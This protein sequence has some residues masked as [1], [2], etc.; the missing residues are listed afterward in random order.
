MRSP[1]WRVGAID[2]DRT[3]KTAR[4]PDIRSA[5]PAVAGGRARVATTE[6]AAHT[7]R[8]RLC[9]GVPLT[10]RDSL[11]VR[12]LARSCGFRV[13]SASRPLCRRPPTSPAT[14][15]SGPRRR[16]TSRT[17]VD[18]RVG[19]P[20][21]R[22]AS[23]WSRSYLKGCQKLGSPPA[24]SSEEPLHTRGAEPKAQA[25]HWRQPTSSPKPVISS[26]GRCATHPA[27]RANHARS[28][29]LSGNVSM[30]PRSSSGHPT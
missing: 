20:P 22:R 17:D 8:A 25:F 27:M 18:R 30:T 11:F 4:P 21:C 23:G 10:C 7:N 2:P 28:S 14:V 24:L 5:P 12:L 19:P 16:R 1:A 29:R 26:A 3:V 15:A 9:T 13:E 6:A